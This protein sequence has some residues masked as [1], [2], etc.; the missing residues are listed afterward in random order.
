MIVSTVI[1]EIVEDKS[2]TS[3]NNVKTQKR[4][5]ELL[6][7][8]EG[9]L[10]FKLEPHNYNSAVSI[11]NFKTNKMKLNKSEK[12][13]KTKICV[14]SNS[15]EKFEQIRNFAKTKEKS[16]S[17]KALVLKKGSKEETKISSSL[18][19]NLEENKDSSNGFFYSNKKTKSKNGL[20]NPKGSPNIDKG[21]GKKK[22]AFNKL[23]NK[24]YQNLKMFGQKKEKKNNNLEDNRKDF[25]TIRNDLK[26]TPIHPAYQSCKSLKGKTK[27]ISESSFNPLNDSVNY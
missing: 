3:K 16:I 22:I 20:T 18:I 26:L 14:N 8:K 27:K 12:T 1:D 19:R 13:K 2:T 9:D 6:K 17:K 25:Q 4:T 10:S 24:T 15:K 5:D 11:D 23:M 7:V 21:T